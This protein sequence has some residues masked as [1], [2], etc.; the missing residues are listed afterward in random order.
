[1]APEKRRTIIVLTTRELE[2]GYLRE[3][4]E[5][6][7]TIWRC[8]LKNKIQLEENLLSITFIYKSQNYGRNCIIIYFE[9]FKPTQLSYSDWAPM[10]QSARLQLN[11]EIGWSV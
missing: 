6:E 10:A 3:I 9:A 2:K 7:A 1:M 4:N 8:P 11:A 5:K